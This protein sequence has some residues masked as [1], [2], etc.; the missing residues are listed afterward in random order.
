MK[1]IALTI[2]LVVFLVLAATFVITLIGFQEE[3]A[4]KGYLEV[5]SSGRAGD[6][7]YYLYHANGS[8][9]ATLFGLDE[10]P[11][12]RVYIL[13]ETG[14]GME[15]FNDFVDEMDTLKEYGMTVEVI[16]RGDVRN[17]RDGVLIVPTGAI[18]DYILNTIGSTGTFNTLVYIGKTDL[19]MAS[20]LRKDY[21]YT[22]LDEE[23]KEK[24]IVK[25]YTLDEFMDD[26]ALVEAFKQEVLENRWAVVSEESH[27]FENYGGDSSLFVPLEET[28]YL[29]FLYTAGPQRGVDSS[30]LLPEEPVRMETDGHVYPWERA[31]VSFTLSNTTGKAFYT[32]EKNGVILLSE[33][34]G[35]VGVEKAFYYTY[36]FEE[37]GDYIVKVYDSSGM[38]GST[39]IHV[40]DIKIVREGTYDIRTVFKVTVDGEPLKSGD[41]YISVN[42]AEAEKY[43]II[44]GRA[45]VAEKLQSGKNV[46]RVQYLEYKEDITYTREQA[47]TIE[48]YLTWGPFI[49]VFIV[50]VYVLA[51][52]RKR[53]MYTIKVEVLSRKERNLLEVSFDDMEK[54]FEY[55]Q[56]KFG[57]DNVP[58]KLSELAYSVR[59]N[60]T[61]GAD[62]L[63]G[64]LE[65]ILKAMEKKG[66]VERYGDYYQLK[67]WGDVKNGMLMRKARDTLVKNGVKFKETK[68]GFDTGSKI[69]SAE[70][71]DLKKKLLLVFD[72][73]EDAR[74]F[75]KS[76]KGSERARLE[77]KKANDMITLVPID[78]L[79]DLL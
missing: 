52:M 69:I 23:T 50:V 65:A 54:C 26:P 12:D 30:G 21:W 47:S 53:P 33:D 44:D 61:D 68:H 17:T 22:Q 79:E 59:K 25:E 11:R 51:S 20:S 29:R 72:G 55:L 71:A 27:I 57:W 2:M 49:L 18:P 40:K 19:K 35:R 38:L 34:L 73:E 39:Y 77:V 9:N 14:I 67:G 66:I 24:I 64:D 60:I 1:K 36:E 6:F 3:E 58:V 37:P 28:G 10:E 4:E 62:V 70:Y 46:F 45:T 16:G 75:M 7:G 13:S 41:L 43:P 8:G 32:V 48:T 63:D 56:D 74:R 76:L 78:R 5:L 15:S 31:A 42:N